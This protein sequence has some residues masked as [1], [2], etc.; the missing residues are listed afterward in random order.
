[1]TSDTIPPRGDVTWREHGIGLAIL[2]KTCGQCLKPRNTTG[3]A[4]RYVR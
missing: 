2:T 4:I 3:G 1:M